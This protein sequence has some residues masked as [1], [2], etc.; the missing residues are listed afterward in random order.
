[1]TVR[2]VE[3]EALIPTVVSRLE[4]VNLVL[5]IGCG[6]MPQKYIR[7]LVHICCEPFG[8]Y[9]EH[10]QKK[11]KNEYDRSY[12]V[13]KATWREAVKIF[14][15]RSVDSVFLVDI[16]EH[17][18]KEEALGLLRETEALVRRQIAVFTPLGF[19]PQHHP[20]GK[21]AW[22]MGGGAWQEHRSGWKPEEFDDSWDVYAS[23]V[24]HTI[25]NMGNELR[26]PYGALWAIKTL[27]HVKKENRR[28]CSKREKIHA[29][30]DMAI[31]IKLNMLLDLF[32]F[33][34]RI[35]LRIK[36][37]RLGELIANSQIIRKMIIGH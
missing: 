3:K 18:E 11:I 17:L 34:M 16:I 13:I 1:V 31:D 10:L 24:F 29:I 6:I 15:P 23:K 7:P 19:F 20:D 8:Q 33:I 12:V 35:V 2:W 14:P 22:G 4:P 5:D 30:V 37:S 25:D 26:P 21:D 32:I 36:A 27:D 9:V 28:I